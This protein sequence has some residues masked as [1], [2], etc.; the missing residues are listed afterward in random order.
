MSGSTTGVD[1]ILRF[2]GFNVE[3]KGVD[4]APAQVDSAWTS[5]A[6]GEDTAGAATV[7]TN[8]PGHKTVNTITLRGPLTDKRAALCTW[9]NDTVSGQSPKRIVEITGINDDGSLGERFVF[10]ECLPVR[11][12]PPQVAPDP[13]GRLEEEVRFAYARVVTL[14]PPTPNG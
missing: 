12:V 14:P 7:R 2:K 4:G 8:S 5:V 6:V 9:V 1:M 3:I 10:F 13:C 11:Y